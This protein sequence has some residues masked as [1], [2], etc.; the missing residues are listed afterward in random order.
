MAK[1]KSGKPGDDEPKIADANWLLNDDPTAPPKPQPKPQPQAKPKPG[2]RP[3]SESG[4]AS[5]SEPEVDHSYDLAGGDD[6]LFETDEAAPPVPPIP[7]PESR[8]PISRL[9]AEEG[10]EAEAQARA[11]ARKSEPEPVDTT[12]TVDQ[13][14]SRGAE[15]GSHLVLMAVA[16]AIIGFIIY[17]ALS[18]HLFLIAMLLLM[19]GG[20]AMMVLGYPLFITLER[21]VRITPEQAAKDYYHM[22]SHM[23]PHYPRMWLMLS[24]AGRKSHEFSS[25]GQFQSYWKRTLARLQGAASS[26]N[27][28]KFKVEDFRADKSAGVTSVNAKF[29]VKV[30]RGEP[31]PGNEVASYLISTGLVKGPDRMWY[32]NSGVLPSERR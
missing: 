22:L 17:L 21:P 28:L 20:A 3:K 29:T 2:P 12:P 14:W 19:L 5:A 26:F 27:S 4:S 10:W 25:F 8:K 32:L 7:A 1:S 31:G 24:S 18:A 6:A 9:D 16:A 23:R 15:W 13:V 11:A 30:Y